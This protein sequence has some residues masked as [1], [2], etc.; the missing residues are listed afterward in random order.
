MTAF[1]NRK[2]KDKTPPAPQGETRPAGQLSWDE[3]A[4]QAIAQALA[5]APVPGLLK[6]KIR[7]ELEKSAEEAAVKTGRSNVT[8]EDV[9]TGMLAKMPASMRE[10]V[11][12]AMKQGPDALKDLEK[13]LRNQK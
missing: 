2:K 5:Q 7:K 13:E 6:G 9:V 12:G 8:A 10:K 11:E 1:W 3:Q 4:K